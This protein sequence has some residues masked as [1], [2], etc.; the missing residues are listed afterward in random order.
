[1]NLTKIKLAL[2]KTSSLYPTTPS[3]G[4]FQAGNQA[5]KKENLSEDSHKRRMLGLFKAWATKRGP[6]ID[7]FDKK[8]KK[9]RRLRESVAKEAAEIQLTARKRALAAMDR[10][11]D[12]I[13]N[14]VSKDS[15]AIAAANVV[16]DRAYGRAQQTNINANISDGKEKSLTSAE[17]NERIEKTLRRA[18]ELTSRTAETGKS[19]ERPAD[20]RLSDTDSGGPTGS[21]H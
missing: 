4:S 11:Q 19:E 17:L 1:M 2:G 20:I 10:L 8:L 16:L 3:S 9:R 18:Q 14:P 6:K 15:D 12:I 7:T 13:E 5:L 21:V